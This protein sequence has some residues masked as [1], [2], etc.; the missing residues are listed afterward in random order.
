MLRHLAETFAMTRSRDYAGVVMLW[1]A[2]DESYQHS[3]ETGHATRVTVGGAVASCSEWLGLESEWQHVLLRRFKIPEFH[4]TDFESNQGAFSGWK[5]TPDRRRELLATALGVIER[6]G[7]K[8]FFG[9][10]R[11]V[12][13]TSGHETAAYRLCV[14]DLI[15]ELARY[16]SQQLDDQFAIM[17]ARRQGFRIDLVRQAIER[18]GKDKFGP[19]ISDRPVNVCALQVADLIA[20]ETRCIQR[21][22][23]ERYPFRCLREIAVRGGGSFSLT[24]R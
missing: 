21:D 2:F 16:K 20:Y 15:A 9:V 5:E 11:E 14:D 12:E 18:E 6:N 13:D 17:F 4:M 22:W 24:F 7:L 3:A 19:I 23:P 10:S 8:H 1:W